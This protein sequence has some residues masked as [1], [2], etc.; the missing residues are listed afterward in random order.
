MLFSILDFKKLFSSIK[1]DDSI[2]IIRNSLIYDGI[3]EGNIF[4]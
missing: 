2:F 4:Q 1:R 3:R